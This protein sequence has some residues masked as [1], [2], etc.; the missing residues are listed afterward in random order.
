MFVKKCLFTL[1]IHLTKKIK[2]IHTSS[3]QIK[4]TRL[5]LH[6]ESLFFINWLII[7]IGHH[8]P[9]TNTANTEH[10]KKW[11]LRPENPVYFDVPYPSFIKY[12][13]KVQYQSHRMKY[14]LTSI[15]FN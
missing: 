8:F 9:S 13:I 4:R 11:E 15:K 2:I 10:E 12:I 7:L 3:L 14:N 1:S 5:L 6:F